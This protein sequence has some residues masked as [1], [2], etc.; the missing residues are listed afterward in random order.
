MHAKEYL[1]V[2]YTFLKF[3]SGVSFKEG[4]LLKLINDNK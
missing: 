3:K 1:N 4:N 2:K